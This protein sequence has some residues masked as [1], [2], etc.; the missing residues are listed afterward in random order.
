MYSDMSM[1]IINFSSSNKNSANARANSVLPT[2]VG[3]RKMN[4]PIGRL[5]SDKPARLRRTALDTRA[6]ASSCPTTHGGRRPTLRHRAPPQAVFHLHEFLR[7][8]LEQTSCRD[9]RPLAHQF[10]DV[11]FVHFFFQHR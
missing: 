1:R 2:P 9:S 6:N 11:F 7:F 4:D 5:L 8:T 10:R 3:P